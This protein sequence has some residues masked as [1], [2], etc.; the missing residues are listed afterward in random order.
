VRQVLSASV[1]VTLAALTVTA[2]Q[3]VYW[4]PGASVPLSTLI[5]C[6]GLV[7]AWRPAWGL[8]ALAMLAPFGRMIAVVWLGGFPIRGPEAMALAFLAGV[9]VRF[10]LRPPAGRVLPARVTGPW[11]LF[12][13]CVVASAAVLYR[14][15]QFYL[16]YPGVFF[17][18]L[19]TY[20]ATNYQG[21]PGDPRPWSELTTFGSVEAA[22]LVVEGIA[23]LFVAGRLMATT[24]GLAI[25]LTATLVTGGVVAALMSIDAF[26]TVAASTAT[27]IGSLVELL[28][29]KRI[30]VHVTKVNT[31][32]SYF[33]MIATLSGGM[34]LRRSSGRL[35]WAVAFTV[36]LVGLW[37][38]ASLAA[39]LA[40]MTVAIVAGALWLPRTEDAG[41]RWQRIT[42]AIV[43]TVVVVGLVRVATRPDAA[44]SLL[45][46]VAITKVS[47][48]TMAAAPVFGV[49]I[50]DYPLRSQPYVTD[51]VREGFGA[52]SIAPHNYL[53]HI[54]AE[55]GVVG[56]A[57]FLWAVVATLRQARGA[58]AASAAAAFVAFLLSA[59]AGQPMLVDAV[60]IPTWLTL[61]ILLSN[62]PAP[63]VPDRAGQPW[64]VVAGIAAIMAMLPLRM[65][66]AVQ[67]QNFA[68]AG[69][70]T[71]LI[72]HP[73]DETTMLV[74]RLDGPARLFVSGAAPAIVLRAGADPADPAGPLFLNVRAVGVMS[75]PLLLPD[76]GER[77]VCLA[78]E[79][80]S[81]QTRPRALDI[82]VVDAAGRPVSVQAWVRVDG[83][84]EPCGHLAAKPAK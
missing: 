37:L 13:T 42:V 27:S 55:L 70:D 73:G 16:D 15:A 14:V 47:L 64:W 20:V 68:F 8:L 61:A 82:E 18:R 10:A 19:L 11:I 50:G 39:V 40:G 45:R 2:A 23:L 69:H 25:R 77:T 49:G 58:P 76:G 78:V 32:G 1:R 79:P 56:I 80:G 60:A 53:L 24:P 33:V 22:A 5:T 31:A 83:L 4:S 17:V 3:S 35:L 26:V 36:L 44:E 84:G 75:P 71:T 38:T 52:G 63:A 43:A 7:A 48:D 29:D 81:A 57:V 30:A 41:R 34:A 9:A 72:E 74:H 6:L 67:E 28:A 51:E 46:R 54:A 66:A 62:A 12:A 65:A 21:I 59:L